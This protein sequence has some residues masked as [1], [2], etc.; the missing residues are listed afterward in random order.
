MREREAY[1]RERGAVVVVELQ[2]VL[3]PVA[4]DV[5]TLA[6]G[7]GMT[8]GTGHA[9]VRAFGEGH[10]HGVVDVDTTALSDTEVFGIAASHHHPSVVED[11]GE[12]LVVGRVDAAVEPYTL[13]EHLSRRGQ[14]EIGGVATHNEHT[15][16]RRDDLMADAGNLHV[17]HTF[18]LQRGGDALLIRCSGSPAF[19]L[20]NGF[21]LRRGSHPNLLGSNSDAAE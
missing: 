20:I 7:D 10:G 8:G 5:D 12:A 1:G 6:Y 3:I 9:Q 15:R 4:R 14:G 16:Y 17:G 13:Q 2:I 11:N 18:I 21:D 19:K